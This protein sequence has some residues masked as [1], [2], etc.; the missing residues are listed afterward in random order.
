MADVD[1][2]EAPLGDFTVTRG[3]CDA[4]VGDVYLYAEGDS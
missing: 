1:L 3:E 4:F 2:L